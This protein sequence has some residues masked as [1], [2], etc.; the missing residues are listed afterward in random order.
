[1]FDKI[2][3]RPRKKF[4]SGSEPTTA[5][6]AFQYFPEGLFSRPG[7]V[8]YPLAHYRPGFAQEHA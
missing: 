2:A 5:A 4:A 3:A 1:M 6:P 8:T 7:W